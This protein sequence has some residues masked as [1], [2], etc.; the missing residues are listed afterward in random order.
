M[1][2]STSSAVP[3]IRQLVSEAV[4]I[5]GNIAQYL[6]DGVATR[7]ADVRDVAPLV[8]RLCHIERVFDVCLARSL[9]NS[10]PLPGS[11]AFSAA[12][13]ALVATGGPSSPGFVSTF[14]RLLMLT[15]GA[16]PPLPPPL[17]TDSL[18]LPDEDP[19]SVSP[20][21]SS[22]PPPPASVLMLRDRLREKM[23]QLG[24]HGHAA[25]HAGSDIA[26]PPGLAR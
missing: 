26:P 14:S 21:A 12:T 3:R 24:M 11:H 9:V 4:E 5:D 7:K 8:E 20:G 23:S 15:G 13:R 22:T 10:P 19:R 1:L 16:P 18:V 6:S 2:G 17:P 25:V